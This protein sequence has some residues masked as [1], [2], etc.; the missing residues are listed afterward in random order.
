MLT[1]ALVV[2][3]PALTGMACPAQDDAVRLRSAAP[4]RAAQV[5]AKIDPGG[6]RLEFVDDDSLTAG[7][8]EA[9]WQIVVPDLAAARRQLGLPASKIETLVAMP[10][11]AESLRV[12][13][14]GKTV[15][16]LRSGVD[17]D[18]D[19]VVVPRLGEF[20][21]IVLETLARYPADG[22]HTYHWP[23]SGSWKGCTKDLE[24]AGAIVCEGD[25]QGR[26][27]C[28]GLTFEVFLDAYRTWC[29]R[30]ARPWRIK[31]FGLKGVRRLQSQW[32]GS[33]ADPSCVY[34]ALVSNDLGVRIE[35][36]NQA[37]PGDFVQLWR[38]SGS[39]HSVV[40]LGWERKQ[41]E[42]VGLR[43]WST[44]TATDGIGERTEWFDQRGIVNGK[45]RRL[46]RERIWICRVGVA[47]KD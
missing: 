39:G 24:Y 7:T 8:A 21:D 35:D 36:W 34:T 27:Y 30:N 4:K 22:T 18:L 12:E 45:D 44:Q 37:R 10:S 13:L 26:A 47:P 41:K 14:P 23:K 40:F 46:D 15:V 42:I 38:H 1:R 2:L 20:N 28:C 31:D 33:A 19:T 11:G 5:L 6:L 25:E 3:L 9:P 32:F 29:A 43:Y 16:V 17:A